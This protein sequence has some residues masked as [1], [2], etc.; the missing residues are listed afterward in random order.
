MYSV[1]KTDNYEKLFCKLLSTHEQREILDFEKALAY[2]PYLG[3]PLKS[4]YYREKRIDGK[5]IHFLIYDE[6]EVVLM[7]HISTKKTQQEV[8]DGVLTAREE[9]KE[10]VKQLVLRDR[11]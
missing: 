2:R 1:R 5:R 8:I 9:Y 7:V 10:Y 4:P 6:F 3:K 11:A